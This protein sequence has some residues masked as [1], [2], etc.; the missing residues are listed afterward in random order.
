MN[1]PNNALEELQLKYEQ[2]AS[3]M[4]HYKL[5]IFLMHKL[6]EELHEA[7]S[8]SRFKLLKEKLDFMMDEVEKYQ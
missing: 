3:A 5:I 7:H 2:L 8:E 6:L 1:C 4:D